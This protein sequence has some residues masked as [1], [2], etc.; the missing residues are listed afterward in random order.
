[1][2]YN[3]ELGSIEYTK[4]LLVEITQ[5]IHGLQNLLSFT[6][7]H[8]IIVTLAPNTDYY[9]SIPLTFPLLIPLSPSSFQSYFT[10]L[11]PHLSTSTYNYTPKVKYSKSFSISTSLLST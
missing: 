10:S 7:W 5:M 6:R 2:Q 4:Y 8:S 1:M 9:Y 3:V 11:H